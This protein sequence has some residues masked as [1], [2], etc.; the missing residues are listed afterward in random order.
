MAADSLHW[1]TAL[2]ALRTLSLRSQS[3]PNQAVLHPLASLSALRA[4]DLQGCVVHYLSS[5]APLEGLRLAW[6][7]LPYSTRHWALPLRLKVAVKKGE[8]EKWPG[9]EDQ[10]LRLIQST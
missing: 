1:L 2:S 6:L 4:L 5:S 8:R 9:S 10:D 7:R 3:Q